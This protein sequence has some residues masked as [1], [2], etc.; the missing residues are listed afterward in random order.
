M[1]RF[2]PAGNVAM[3]TLVTNELFSDFIECRYRGYLKITDAA[4][5]KSDLVDLSRK[6]RDG[7]LSQ[8]RE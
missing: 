2:H 3:K 6:L 4:G 7:Y 1:R 5:P 8:A